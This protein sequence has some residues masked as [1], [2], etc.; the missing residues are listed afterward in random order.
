MEPTVGRLAVR[1]SQGYSWSW[2]FAAGG[3]CRALGH[4][5]LKL[6][7]EQFGPCEL[8]FSWLFNASKTA[9]A[10]FSPAQDIATFAGFLGVSGCSTD[11][12]DF[13]L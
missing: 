4:F 8:E 3:S 9:A 13:D 12:E 6:T 11:R 2:F 5:A 10:I 1:V 7:V